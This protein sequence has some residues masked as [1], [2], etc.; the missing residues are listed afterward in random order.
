ME[1]GTVILT[2][3]VGDCYFNTWSGGLTVQTY[4]CYKWA[5]PDISTLNI[6]YIVCVSVRVHVCVCLC[7]CACMCVCVHVFVS[8]NACAG[9]CVCVCVCVCM[10]TCVCV[11]GFHDTC[12]VFGYTVSV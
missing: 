10:R 4:H 8:M 12:L 11:L 3:G 6:M 2:Y 1:W 5:S 7:V 9:V